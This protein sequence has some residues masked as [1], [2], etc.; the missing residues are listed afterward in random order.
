MCTPRAPRRRRARTVDL[1][2]FRRLVGN[3]C[4]AC[5]IARTCFLSRHE[6]LALD[7]HQATQPR[8]LQIEPAF[9]AINEF[10]VHA[11]S[12]PSVCASVCAPAPTNCHKRP[13]SF[14]GKNVPQVL[15]IQAE[16]LSPSPARPEVHAARRSR[17]RD[18]YRGW[19]NATSASLDFSRLATRF[20]AD[21]ANLKPPP[22]PAEAALYSESCAT[23][24][25]KP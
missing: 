12:I 10:A 3:N 9:K 18:L 13:R 4:L 24:H 15:L 22:V 2:D 17:C 19:L 21:G 23:I 7:T 5:F 1:F 11:R 6:G 20:C 14:K 8:A 16:Y 25:Q